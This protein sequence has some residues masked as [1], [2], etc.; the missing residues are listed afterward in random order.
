[1]ENTMAAPKVI[2]PFYFYENYK[3][4]KERNNTI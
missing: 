3:R 1:M 4:Y 2:P